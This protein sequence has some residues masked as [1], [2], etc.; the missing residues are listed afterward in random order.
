LVELLFDLSN[1]H[2]LSFFAEI[3]GAERAMKDVAAA[4]CLGTLTGALDTFLAEFRGVLQ[5]ISSTEQ[6]PATY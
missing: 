2:G 5:Y 6:I 3:L 1:S 4:D